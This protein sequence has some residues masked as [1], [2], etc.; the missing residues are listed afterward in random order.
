MEGTVFSGGILHTRLRVGSF[1][2][3]GN[4]FDFSQ[5]EAGVVFWCLNPVF[6]RLSRETC[7]GLV[8]WEIWDLWGKQAETG[9]PESHGA[10]CPPPSAANPS[11]IL[12]RDLDVSHALRAVPCTELS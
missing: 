6:L 4:T 1:S 11:F 3:C 10:E 5:G 12:A 2:Y 8:L 9:S 7:W